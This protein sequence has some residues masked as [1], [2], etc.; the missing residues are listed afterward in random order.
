MTTD[1]TA[2]AHPPAQ[3]K[4]VFSAAAGTWSA[5]CIDC[6]SRWV[7][8]PAADPDD[9]PDSVHHALLTAATMAELD[10]DDT[11]RLGL[12]GTLTPCGELHC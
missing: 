2:C 10:E 1:P 4:V 8:T 11:A 12:T 9:L 5:I 6:L 7:R 3:V